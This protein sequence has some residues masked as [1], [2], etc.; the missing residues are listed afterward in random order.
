M[1]SRNLRFVGQH[2]AN[3][4]VPLHEQYGRESNGQRKDCGVFLLIWRRASASVALL[5]ISGASHA[6]LLV[7]GGN[8][9]V[10]AFLGR[11]LASMLRR[12]FSAIRARSIKLTPRV[13]TVTI[14]AARYQNAGSV[15]GTGMLQDRRGVLAAF[16]TLNWFAPAK[17]ANSSHLPSKVVASASPAGT[18]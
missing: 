14:M 9:R 18:D 17:F 13:Y 6:G 10:S 15:A 4:R 5:A 8:S 12:G 1:R 11:S 7:V 2:S 16:H 3:L